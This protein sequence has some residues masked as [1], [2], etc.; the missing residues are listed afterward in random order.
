MKLTNNQHP[1]FI[2]LESELKALGGGFNAHLHLDRADTLDDYYLNH[3]DL[4]PLEKSYISLQ[5]KHNLI[6]DLHSGPAYDRNDLEERVNR[7]LD[8][9]I[10]CGTK[11]ADTMV[12][13]TADRVQLSALQTL[14]DIKENRK[15]EIDLRLASYSPLGFI[16][17][18][19]ERWEI[20]SEG[21]K[22]ADFIGHLPEADDKDDY[23]DH[24]GFDE[25][26]FRVLSLA[27]E[28][29]KMVHFHTDQRNLD[30]ESG[31]ERVAD[32]VEKHGSP[33]SKDGSPM[34]WVVHAIS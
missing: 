10:E 9:M 15:H 3:V 5:K 28:L 29:N 13:V 7:N 33:S 6:N 14:M 26:C 1:W 16:D 27:R 8:L 2:K 25:S 21:A 22:M 17:S 11:R 32:A 20:Y 12:D 18:Q 30:S 34:I 24:I 31:T 23:P 19:P 4:Q